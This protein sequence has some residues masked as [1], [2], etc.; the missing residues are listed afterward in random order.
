MESGISL[1]LTVDFPY[2]LIDYQP[3]CPTP[4][5]SQSVQIPMIIKF[6]NIHFE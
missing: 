2:E 6:D 5:I 3:R 1:N 4:R